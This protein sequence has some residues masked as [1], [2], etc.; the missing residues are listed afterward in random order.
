MLVGTT[1]PTTPDG[2]GGTGGS[3]RL[4]GDARQPPDST[5]R[6]SRSASRAGD[7][8]P[9]SVDPLDPP[10]P[11]PGWPPTAAAGCRR[12]RRRSRCRGRRRRHLRGRCSPAATPPPSPRSATRSHIDLQDLEPADRVPLPLPGGRAHLADRT[13]PHG[14][15]RRCRGRRAPVRHGLVP[16]VPERPLRRPPRHRRPTSST[17]SCSSATTSTSTPAT[18]TRSGPS[19]GPKCIT[20][21][22]LPPPVRR[23]T[24]ATRSCSRPTRS[25]PWIV[26]W[27]DHEVENNHA[28]LVSEAGATPEDFAEQ[29][30]A[31]YQ[32]YYEH[33]P[34][35]LDAARGPR[36]AASTAA[37]R[38]GTLAELFV[39]D[40]RQY[41]DDQPCDAALGRP[42]RHHRVRHRGRGERHARRRPGG[43]AHRRPQRLHARPGRSSPSRR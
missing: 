17:W 22:R 33:L 7:P 4:A 9:T 35:R 43:V 31:A 23:S 26:T 20:L 6:R 34:L 1:T 19:T 2:D 27:D 39:L 16:G 25:A 13:H 5:P 41:R 29:R 28:D 42:R 10:G 8:L 18:R 11:R 12:R 14:P 3:E 30:F 37:S 15:G 32:A 21:G 40:G 38:W 36:L 24:R